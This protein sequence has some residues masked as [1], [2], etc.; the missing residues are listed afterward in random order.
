MKL[1][2]KTITLKEMTSRSA[3]GAGNNKL[4]PLTELMCIREKDGKLVMITSDGT[5]Y[6]Y[7]FQDGV[8]VE[9]GFYVTVKAEQFAKLVS[10]LTCESVE[11]SLVGTALEVN[12]N[13]VYKIDI[14]VDEEGDVITYPDPYENMPLSNNPSQI[15]LATIK[16]I[17]ECCKASLAQTLEVPCYTGYY[18]GARV[19]ATDN[20]KMSSM[21]VRLFENDVL[22]P[23]EVFNLVDVMT[24]EKIDFQFVGEYLVFTSPD[25]VVIG[26]PMDGIEDYPIEP[27][28]ELL[29]QDMESSC[30]INR[31]SFISL[32]E[33]IMLFVGPYDDKA[34][35]LTF[36]ENGIAVQSIQSNG[37]ETIPYVNVDNFKPFTCLADITFLLAE[38]KSIQSDAL[39]MQYGQDNAIR[40]DDGNITI[41]VSL[42]ADTQGE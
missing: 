26:M 18:C 39:K 30:T 1:K 4:L 23:A 15:Q 24:A 42:L 21:K 14:P 16:S 34:I 2:I 7:I 3:K 36:T 27:I 37:V 11:M 25:C 40:F 19:V 31:N 10:K 35:R 5:N 32:L 28:S 29:E 17:L 12:G 38:A 33:R 6:L 13:G 20:D 9:E 22:V 8:E 41:V